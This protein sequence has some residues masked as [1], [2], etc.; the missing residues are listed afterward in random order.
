MKII[1]HDNSEMIVT[2]TEEEFCNILGCNS[3][4]SDEYKALLKAA[5]AKRKY[6][7]HVTLKGFEISVEGL[8]K[9]VESIRWQEQ[10][11]KDAVQTLRNLAEAL[12]VAWPSLVMSEVAA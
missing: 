11:A 12:E 6:G 5:E 3:T 4:Y 10:K 8:H 9:K 2:M 1:A 7:G